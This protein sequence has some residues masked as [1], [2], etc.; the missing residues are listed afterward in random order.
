[1]FI[2]ADNLAD[3]L[4]LIFSDLKP[5]S[6]ILSAEGP[7]IF[8]T[9]VGSKMEGGPGFSHKRSSRKLFFASASFSSIG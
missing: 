3:S 8:A 1:M 2:W 5:H 6:R 7:F 9:R 4:T